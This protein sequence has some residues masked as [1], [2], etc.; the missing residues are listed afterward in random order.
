MKMQNRESETDNDELLKK[1]Y[2]IEKGSSFLKSKRSGIGGINPI[3][4]FLSD[5]KSVLYKHL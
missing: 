3:L 5:E 2:N 4:R 1:I